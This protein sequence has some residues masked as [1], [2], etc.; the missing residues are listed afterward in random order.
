MAQSYIKRILNARVYDVARE[1]PLDAAPLLSGRIGN[2]AFLKRE[3]LQPVFSFKCRGA[4]NKMTTSIRLPVKRGGGCLSRQSR[5]RRGAG[6]NEAGYQSQ[7]RH[8]CHHP[9]DQGRCGARAGRQ[10]I[11]AW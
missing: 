1:T 4:Y 2:H 11:A 7:N 10:G 5:S 9:C 3:D 6:G 8:A